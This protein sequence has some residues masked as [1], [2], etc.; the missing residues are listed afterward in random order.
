MAMPGTTRGGLTAT[1][2]KNAVADSPP[3]EYTLKQYYATHPDEYSPR[4]LAYNLAHIRCGEGS[5]GACATRYN[6]EQEAAAEQ[7]WLDEQREK[8]SGGCQASRVSPNFRVDFGWFARTAD[9]LKHTAAR[10]AGIP[11]MFVHSK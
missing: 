8:S 3:A 4:D 11:P 1:E 5:G 10:F 9:S 6:I 7:R 2:W